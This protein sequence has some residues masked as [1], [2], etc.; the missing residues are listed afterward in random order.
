MALK[1]RHKE[2][3]MLTHDKM[4]HITKTQAKFFENI[5]ISQRVLISDETKKSERFI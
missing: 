4:A 3:E 1:Q 5:V 2:T